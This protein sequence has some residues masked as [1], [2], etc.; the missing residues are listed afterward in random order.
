MKML[1]KIYNSHFSHLFYFGIIS[2]HIFL[3]LPLP[4]YQGTRQ[5]FIMKM[6]STHQDPLSRLIKEGVMISTDGSNLRMNSRANFRQPKVSRAIRT[7]GLGDVVQPG[8]QQPNNSVPPLQRATSGRDNTSQSQSQG[9][10]PPSSTQTATT[11]RR[12]NTPRDPC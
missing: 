8:A 7:K 4:L 11:S 5:E 1:H 6:V 12:S 2:I 10:V 3:P 9:L